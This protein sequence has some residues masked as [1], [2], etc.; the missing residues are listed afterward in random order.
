MTQK[1]TVTLLLAGFTALVLLA[2]PAPARAKA[3]AGAKTVHRTIDVKTAHDY[4]QFHKQ[5]KFAYFQIIDL[6]T[7]KEFARGR[8]P[9]AKNIEANKRIRWK[10]Y[11]LTKKKAYMVYCKNGKTGKRIMALM[12]KLRFKE[13]YNIADGITAW[14]RRK[15]PLKRGTD[16]D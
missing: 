14:K 3:G 12:K 13:V 1:R 16:N 15:Y 11:K 10:L 2:A 8:I 5:T 9:G 4:W 7:D 6:R